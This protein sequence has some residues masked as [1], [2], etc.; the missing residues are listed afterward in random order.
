MNIF[1]SFHWKLFLTSVAIGLV[2]LTT[3]YSAD[4]HVT[5]Q[6]AI[7]QL[8]WL[9]V[10]IGVMFF[11]FVIGYR[12]FLNM[13]YIFYV[14]ALGLL[15]VV[16]VMG[17]IRSGAQRWIS[18][19]TIGIQ[20][21]E[22]AKMATIL[23]LAS[24][25][26]SQKLI[27]RRK[28]GLLAAFLL[29]FVPLIM[30]VKQ[31]D[32]GTAMVFLPFLF[33]M[34]FVWG[35]KIRH[36]VTT[37]LLGLG[38]LPFVWLNLREYQQRRIL[39]FM[40]PNIDPLGSGYTAIQSKI[41]VGSGGL[42]G[43]GFLAGTQNKLAFLPEDHTDFIFGVLA[44][45]WGFLG[46]LLLLFLY[47]ILVWQMFSIVLRTT[48]LRARLLGT[49]IVSMFVFHIFINIGMTIGLMPIAGLPLPL[50]SY[51]GSSLVS[52]FVA[53]GLMLGIYKERSFF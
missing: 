12:P 52:F 30:I 48:D 29:T 44:E 23:T 37:V 18:L 24:F 47:G 9:G 49:G 19:G 34:L 20:P 17:A 45:E 3:I 1:K 21:S 27:A 31:P 39:V 16:L 46:S 7:K 4:A 11:V 15:G 38:A 8:V 22:F 53:I 6:F 14:L 35:A 5:G 36:L 2:G 41:A 42:L 51:G 32:L 50:M 26:E 13:S 10:A 33:C 43:K 25:L 40:N 28:R